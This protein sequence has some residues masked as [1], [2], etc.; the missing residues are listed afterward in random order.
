MYK[1]KRLSFYARAR[2][3]FSLVEMIGVLA[4]IAI[5]AVIIVPKVFSTIASSRV[6]STAGSITSIK[7]TVS[8]FSGKYGT[9]P[10]T[11]LATSRLDDLFLTPT[12]GLMDSRFVVKIGTQT[13]TAVARGDTWAQAAATGIWTDTGGGVSQAALSRLICLTSTVLAPNVSLGTN[14]FLDGRLSLPVGSRVVSAVIMQC[15]GAEAR[16]LSQKIDGDSM[17]ATTAIAADNV[18]KVV[19]AAPNAAGLTDVYVYIAHQ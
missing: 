3:G 10:L 12:V 16:E 13:G 15:T 1:T 18:G 8:D 17:S 11:T 14:Y 5:L 9:I 19:Y 2:S 7:A 6:T 4:I